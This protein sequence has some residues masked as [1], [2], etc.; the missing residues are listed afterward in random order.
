MNA[1]CKSKDMQTWIKKNNPPTENMS[2]LLLHKYVNIQSFSNEIHF[3]L[4]LS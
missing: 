2:S 4:Y 3:N 1:F